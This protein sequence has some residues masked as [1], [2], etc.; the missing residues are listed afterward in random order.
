MTSYSTT[1]ATNPKDLLGLKKPLLH[2]VPPAL[3]LWV[4]KVFGF[5]AAKY[6]PYNWREKSVRFTVYIDAMERHLMALKDG[7]LFD[8]ESGLP[9]EAHIAAGCAIMLDARATGNMIND[10]K[11]HE[12]PAPKLIKQLTD[13][14]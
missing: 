14:K 1:D 3:S 12:G 13:S 2:L 9:H 6:G 5:S 8:G 7:E 10:R 11:W 4:S